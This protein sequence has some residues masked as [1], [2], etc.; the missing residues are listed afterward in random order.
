VLSSRSYAL[1]FIAAIVAH[2]TLYSVTF[3]TTT[4]PSPSASSLQAGGP[5][6][7]SMPQSNSYFAQKH[8]VFNQ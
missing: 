2:G 7:S 8:N 5:P 3:G 6:P 4:A 1:I